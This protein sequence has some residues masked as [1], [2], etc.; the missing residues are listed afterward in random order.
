MR[1][2]PSATPP[3]RVRA[4]RALREFIL[5]PLLVVWALLLLAVAS[6]VG[7]QAHGAFFTGLR[8]VLEHFIGA[9]T[10]SSTLGAIA[11]GLVTVTS[12][13]FSVLLLAVQQTASNLSP[14]VFD[15]FVRRRSNQVYLGLFVGLALFS[16]IVTA[17]V[18]PK[19][20]PIIGAFIATVLTV[21]ALGCLLFLIYST[22]DQ[23]RPD[24]V[25][26]HLHDRAVLAHDRETEL[27]RRTRRTSRSELP[28][29]AHYR[30]ETFGYVESIDV[31]RIAAALDDHDAG[32]LVEVELRVSVGQEI[33]VGDLIAQVRHCDPQAAAALCSSLAKAVP[34]SPTPDLDYDPRTALRNIS[35]IAWTSGSTAKQNPS[36]AAQ[37]LQAL[38]DLASRWLAEGDRSGPDPLPIVYPDG[39]VE[40]ILDAMYSGVVAAHESRQHQ[41]ATQ[42]V[43]AYQFLWPRANPRAQRR[44]RR[45]VAAMQQLLDQM[46]PSPNLSSERRTLAELVRVTEPAVGTEGAARETSGLRR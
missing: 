35:N 29:R 25:I 41:Q 7:D 5:A 30:S 16:Y 34:I 31:D 17:A 20:P 3:L 4:P 44:I 22:I 24:N 27:I 46:P 21:G 15:Q 2:R 6:I 37:G 38:R 40:L 23:M 9:Q 11:T 33:T 42:V 36:V 12:I 18:Q 32:A 10:A 39:D 13:T 8:R 19:T 26:R 45:D 43:K 28:V 1:D 14:V